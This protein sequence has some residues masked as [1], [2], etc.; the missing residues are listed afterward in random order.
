VDAALAR[1]GL[2]IRGFVPPRALREALDPLPEALRIKYGTARAL[3]AAVVALPYGEGAEPPPEW[4]RAWLVERPGPLA[5]LARFARSNWYGELVRRLKRAVV[6]ARGDLRADG[7]APGSSDAG[8]IAFARALPGEWRCLVNSGLPEKRLALAAGIGT[9]GRHGLVMVPEAGPACVLGLLLLPFETETDTETKPG[10]EARAPNCLR[11]ALGEACGACRACVEACPTGALSDDGFE[12]LR[13]IQHWTAIPGPLPPAVEAAWGTRLYGC[14]VCLAACPRFRPDP[15]A[16]T[17][18]GRL[19]TG[20]PASWLLT[21]GETEIRE[22]FRGT[23]LG[24]AW[25]SK[26]AF[27]RNARLALRG[28]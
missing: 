21:A 16:R 15:D 20:L 8:G 5:T 7:A 3:G 19:G 25:M 13:C 24:M 26:E 4:A 11:P 23:V 6:F 27:R 17:E 18:L 1:A 9:L 28:I 14:D 10:R 12:R 2:A 22:R